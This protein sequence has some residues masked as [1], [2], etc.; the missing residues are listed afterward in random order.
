MSQTRI[1]RC[2]QTVFMSPIHTSAF[3]YSLSTLVWVKLSFLCLKHT[4]FL[5]HNDAAAQQPVV[6]RGWG[7]TAPLGRAEITTQ[8]LNTGGKSH[9]SCFCWMLMPYRT[10]PWGPKLWTQ[11]YMRKYHRIGWNQK[12]VRNHTRT[13]EEMQVCVC[14]CVC[15]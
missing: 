8:P 9:F 7:I 3:L 1:S 12:T 14:V 11:G 6:G 10:W 5:S 15:V 4:P 13:H 2:M